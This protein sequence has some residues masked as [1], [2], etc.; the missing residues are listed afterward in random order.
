M[1]G[2]ETLYNNAAAN[3]SPGSG[4][5]FSYTNAAHSLVYVIIAAEASEDSKSAGGY[6]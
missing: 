6:G 2:T 1:S 3:T 5:S 4:F